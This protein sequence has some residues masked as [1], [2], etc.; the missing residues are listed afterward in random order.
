MKPER[1][2]LVD[3][4]PR[5]VLSQRLEFDSIGEAVRFIGKM[6]ELADQ[7]LADEHQSLE[8]DLRNL[9]VTVRVGAAASVLTARESDF[10]ER[11]RGIA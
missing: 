11:V 6:S 1:V 7:S 3:P 9:V 2:Q 5:P 10:M 4:S 8:I